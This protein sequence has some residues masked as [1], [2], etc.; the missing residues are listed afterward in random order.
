[1]SMG[2]FAPSRGENKQ[3]H[4][5]VREYLKFHGNL[6]PPHQFECFLIIGQ[7]FFQK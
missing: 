2:D 6:L 3:Q 5:K 4:H 1:M 7:H